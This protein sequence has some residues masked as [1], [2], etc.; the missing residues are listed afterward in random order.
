MWYFEN[1]QILKEESYKGGKEEGWSI[2]YN[3]TGKVILRGEYVNGLPEGDWFYEIGDHL[4]EGKYEYGLKQ[5]TWKHTYL[6]NGQLRFKGEFFDDAPQGKHVWYFDNGNKML[7]GE[8]ISGI[9]DGEWRRYYSDGTIMMTIEYESG[10]ETKVDGS[11]L[12]F[13]V[14][15]EEE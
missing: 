7:E 12:K 2:E 10:T 6:S 8:Y 3:D 4:E 9:K 13:K 14:S 11:K 5:G 1:G 15:S